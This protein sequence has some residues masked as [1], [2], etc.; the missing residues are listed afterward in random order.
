MPF[1]LGLS[2]STR[3]SLRVKGQGVSVVVGRGLQEG[4]CAAG[5]ACRGGWAALGEAIVSVGAGTFL[6]P[7]QFFW[8]A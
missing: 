4:C 1:N 2:V 7:S 6:C 5:G 8:L 3:V